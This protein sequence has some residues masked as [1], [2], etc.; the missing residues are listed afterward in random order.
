[1]KLYSSSQI[2][3]MK[4]T[5]HGFYGFVKTGREIGVMADI[6]PGFGW[7]ALSKE[8]PLKELEKAT[9]ELYNAI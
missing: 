6:Y 7:F 2:V 4:K 3:R 8:Q 5:K 1:M 9:K